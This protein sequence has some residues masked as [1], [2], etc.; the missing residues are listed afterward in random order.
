MD[1]EDYKDDIEEMREEIIDDLEDSDPARNMWRLREILNSYEA[2]PNLISKNKINDSLQLADD[3]GQM[4]YKQW[5][6]RL[7]LLR[8]T[9]ENLPVFDVQEF[10]ARELQLQQVLKADMHSHQR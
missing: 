10:N 4:N 3:V 7:D 2:L 8:K 6:E 5:S 9:N 1:Y